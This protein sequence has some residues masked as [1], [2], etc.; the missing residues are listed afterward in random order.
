MEKVKYLEPH[1]SGS[2][3]TLAEYI[4]NSLVSP[5]LLDSLEQQVRGPVD[6][7]QL[8]GLHRQAC[9]RTRFQPQYPPLPPQD[10]VVQLHSQP[11]ALIGELWCEQD[12]RE[13]ASGSDGGECG[14]QQEPNVEPALHKEF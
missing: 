3:I 2:F 7:Q 13:C 1:F 6:Q 9:Q 8:L 4:G 11:K 14:E 12:E 5:A 10:A